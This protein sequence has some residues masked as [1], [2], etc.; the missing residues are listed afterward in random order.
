[1]QLYRSGSKTLHIL[2]L[3][4]LQETGDNQWTMIKIKMN[5]IY[6]VKLIKIFEI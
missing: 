2:S 1:M 6:I 4:S 5:S 3:E